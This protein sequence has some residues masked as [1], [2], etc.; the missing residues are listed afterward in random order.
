MK[1]RY[2]YA[3]AGLLS[4]LF[5]F[6]GCTSGSVKKEYAGE[7]TEISGAGLDFYRAPAPVKKVFRD[8]NAS[9]VLRS[10]KFS[11]GNMVYCEIRSARRNTG[12]IKNPVL[13][14]E[15]TTVQLSEKSYGF[16]GLFPL[17]ADSSAGKKKL[18]LRYVSGKKKHILKGFFDVRKTKF[19]VSR[20]SL[21]LG[22]YS[23]Q[24]TE[25]SPEI[26]EFI[27]ECSKKK[28]ESFASEI[29][30]QLKGK[31]V[32]P[33]DMHYVTSKFWSSRVYER[34]K[35]EDGRKIR[36]KDVTR[37]H[38]GMDLRGAAGSPVF[39]MGA[40]KIVLAQ[41]M[42]YEGN[43]IVVDHGN[44]FFT[45]YMHMSSL[46]V[47]EGD[48]VKAGDLIGRVGSTGQSTGPHLHVSAIMNGEQVNP[49]SLLC[50]PVRE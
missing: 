3:A 16:M 43:M 7:E 39:S 11:Q 4:V 23:T 27:E 31:F 20:S 46:N 33:R 21:N 35:I 29:P 42:Y 47:R 24:G 1:Y 30:D 15:G 25:D 12:Q 41:L 26:K 50:L 5:I 6:T 14:V 38:K 13:T 18:E 19:P 44:R 9:V 48:I 34:Y 2:I 8:R 36:L 45:V 49:M 28:A 22:K 32:H 40:G 10:E 37:T 17:G